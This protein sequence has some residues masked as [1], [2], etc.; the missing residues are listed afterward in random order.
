VEPHRHL[1]LLVEDHDDLREAVA[2]L[3]RCEDYAVAEATDGDDALA[4][5]Q[6]GLSP[7]LVLL[8]LNMPRA[9]GWTFR[10]AQKHDPRL[11][12]IP[13]VA[14]SGHSGV[15]QQAEALG[16]A[17]YLSKPLDVEKLLRIVQRTCRLAA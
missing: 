16:M 2:E 1:L 7:C 4:Q 10:A 8:D 5:L 3:L 13:I 14:L 6:A 15:A 11:A 9:S 12:A 17:D